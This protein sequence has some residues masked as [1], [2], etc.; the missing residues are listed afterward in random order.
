MFARVPAEYQRALYGQRWLSRG[1]GVVIAALRRYI[2]LRGSCGC[3]KEQG[4]RNAGRE[5]HRFFS[6]RERLGTSVDRIVTC[7]TIKCQI[8]EF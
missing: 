1:S 4:D 8:E 7:E 5:V 3:D 2:D 6:G